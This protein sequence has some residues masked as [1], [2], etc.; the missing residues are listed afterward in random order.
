MTLTSKVIKLLDTNY[1]KSF[2]GDDFSL[3]TVKEL[4]NIGIRA[5]SVTAFI[6]L[7][8]CPDS[9]LLPPP[10]PYITVVKRWPVYSRSLRQAAHLET[11]RHFQR[12]RVLT[13]GKEQ[14]QY[15]RRRA[16]AMA[17]AQRQNKSREGGKKIRSGFMK[18]NQKLKLNFSA[19]TLQRKHAAA[20]PKTLVL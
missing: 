16:V 10:T 15:R 13:W 14:M 11:R 20:L 2:H 18:E 9:Q 12:R 1:T 3:D 17:V 8:L 19:V 5:S 4:F 6:H 7:Q